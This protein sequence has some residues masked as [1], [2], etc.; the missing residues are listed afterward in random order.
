MELTKADLKMVIEM[1]D[2]LDLCAGV[3]GVHEVEI[4][5]RGEGGDYI[6]LGYGESG[7]PAIL[8]V[9]T[10]LQQNTTLT[11]LI[12]DWTYRPQPIYPNPAFPYPIINNPQPTCTGFGG[13]LGDGGK[14]AS[15]VFP[16]PKE[17]PMKDYD[18]RF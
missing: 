16:L 18:Q 15:N 6:T 8:D 9:T 17:A 1:M 11:P 5:F 12:G 10:E 13:D 14:T 2:K 3:T 4:H 7:E